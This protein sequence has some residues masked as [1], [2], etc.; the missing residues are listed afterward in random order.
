MTALVPAGGSAAVQ[1]GWVSTS[2]G[3]KTAAAVLDVGV[4]TADDAVF[5]TAVAPRSGP[6]IDRIDD[7]GPGAVRI[8]GTVAGQRFVDLLLFAGGAAD[9]ASLDGQ[10]AFVRTL[11]SGSDSRRRTAVDACG[12]PARPLAAPAGRRSLRRHG[13]DWVDE[14]RLDVGAGEG[15]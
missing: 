1:P 8:T 5:V 4:R 9:G 12:R 10:V 15:R 3:V 7:A 2:Y 6:V 13:R 11:G 14:H